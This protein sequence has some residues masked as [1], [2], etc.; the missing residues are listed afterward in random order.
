[1]LQL[2]NELKNKEIDKHKT[3]RNYLVGIIALFIIIIMFVS[4]VGYGLISSQ[5]NF[6]NQ[7][8]Q[9]QNQINISII[10]VKE[11]SAD[12]K[13]YVVGSG[14][15]LLEHFYPEG[16]AEC[17]DLQSLL[18]NFTVQFQQNMVLE[19]V[20]G[21]NQTSLNMIIYKGGDRAAIIPLEMNNLTADS[22][23]E[24]FCDNSPIRPKECLLRE[25][26]APST[27]NVENSTI[28][29]INTSLETKNTTANM[30]E[31]NSS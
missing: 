24:F 8:Q 23:F 28:T 22:L 4:I 16:C 5:G 26:N 3:T 21:F 2:D 10:N 29:E 12:E 18:V 27:T 15:V 1:M 20:P 14:R 6:Q 7:P 25:F 30:T 13:R 19:T 17:L 9:P 11:L 31:T